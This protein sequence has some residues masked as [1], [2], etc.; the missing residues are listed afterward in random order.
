VALSRRII[1]LAPSG[2]YVQCQCRGQTAAQNQYGEDIGWF[3]PRPDCRGFLSIK[4]LLRLNF[5]N[6]LDVYSSWEAVVEH[7][8]SLTLS[9]PGKD[10]ITA[11]AGVAGEFAAALGSLTKQAAWSTYIAGL[12]TGDIYRGLLWI[13]ASPERYRRLGGFPTWSWASI[14]ATVRWPSRRWGVLEVY[15]VLGELG[16]VHEGFQEWTRGSVVPKVRLNATVFG[17]RHG[18]QAPGSQLSTAPRVVVGDAAATIA[19]SDP[20]GS[21]PPGSMQTPSCQHP[22]LSG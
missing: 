18:L 21:I 11:L 6:L 20:S 3:P 10:R 19:T 5:G 15:R 14:D 9:E 12:W 4:A 7:Y 22:R 17:E 2:V 16:C 8:S 1:C 13:Q